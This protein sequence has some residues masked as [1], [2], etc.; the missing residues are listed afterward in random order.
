VTED[1][2][3]SA[4]ELSI[5][6]WIILFRSAK[7]ARPKSRIFKPCVDAATGSSPGSWFPGSER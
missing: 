7:G 3:E 5:W 4:G 2:A 6:K 1:D